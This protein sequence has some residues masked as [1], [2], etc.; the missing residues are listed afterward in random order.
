MLEQLLAKVRIPPI[1]HRELLGKSGPDA[2]RLEDALGHFVEVAQTNPPAPE[3]Q[4]V[5]WRLDAGEQRA[6][7]A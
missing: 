6:I 7:G 1:V 3:V 5:T 2:A 4:A